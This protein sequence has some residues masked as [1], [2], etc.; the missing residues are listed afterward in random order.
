MKWS[1]TKICKL[2]RVVTGKTP[3]TANADFF[4]GEYPFVTPSDLDYRNY[5]CR[6]TDRTV[7]DKARKRLNNT[8]IPKNAVMFTCIGNTIGKCAIASEESLTNQQINS[9]IVN[10]DNDFKFVYY[11][12]VNNL[13]FI[14]KLGGGAATPII[15]KTMFEQIELKVPLLPIQRKITSLLSAYDDLIEN[16]NR[17]IALLE[18]AARLVYE[19]WF[20]RLRFP[21]Y[22]HAKVVE[23]V[24]KEWGKST[25]D[26]VAVINGE[27]IASSFQ[28]EIEYIDISSVSVGAI[29][30][31]SRLNFTNAPSRARR[32]VKHGDIIWSCVR[33]NRRSYAIIWEPSPS[34]VASTGFAVLTPKNIPTSFLYFAVTTDEFVGYLT[35]RARGAAYPAVVATDFEEAQIIVPTPNL[36]KAF[37]E[38]ITPMITQKEKLLLQNQK[39]KQA[40]DLLLPKLMSG[41]VSV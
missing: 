28:G 32:I 27:T 22:E 7:S 15:N 10:D 4:D 34:V 40:R 26:E 41:E 6:K 30:E 11:L 33:P 8:F 25:L 12:L 14:K 29:N 18:K 38:L 17:R 36:V 9:I 21:G 31:T 1:S 37:D 24:P 19:E 16:N 2:G 39:L 23:G 5:Y 3:P 35:N 20:V 13:D